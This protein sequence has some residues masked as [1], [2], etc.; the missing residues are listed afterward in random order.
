[1]SVSLYLSSCWCGHVLLVRSI[2]MKN[3]T[4]P[5]GKDETLQNNLQKLE[6]LYSCNLV[7]CCCSAQQS[8]LE[9]DRIVDNLK[10]LSIFS[11][12]SFVTGA[13]L[14]PERFADNSKLKPLLFKHLHL[15]SKFLQTPISN[16]KF[17]GR[18]HP[19]GHLCVISTSLKSLLA[20]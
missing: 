17:L 9:F 19:S 3:I 13:A 18:S 10:L 7:E 15:L 12:F 16:T 11:S 2:L 8:L 6:M 1:M 4:W 5:K 20:F 14:H